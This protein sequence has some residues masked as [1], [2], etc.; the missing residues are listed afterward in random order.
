MSGIIL[1]C[2]AGLK[3]TVPLKFRIKR[4]SLVFT[5]TAR[6]EAYVTYNCQAEEAEHIARKLR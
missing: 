6:H 4:L 2:R 3:A 1:L 5:D